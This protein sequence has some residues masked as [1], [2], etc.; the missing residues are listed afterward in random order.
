MIGW[1]AGTTNCQLERGYGYKNEFPRRPAMTINLMQELHS[2][3]QL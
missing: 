1:S 3:M 2:Y